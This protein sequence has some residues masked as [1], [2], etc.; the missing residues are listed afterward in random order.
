[1]CSLSTRFPPRIELLEDRPVV[2]GIRTHVKV[3]ARAALPLGA[4]GPGKL[5]LIYPVVSASKKPLVDLECI[6]LSLLDL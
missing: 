3:L 6:C 2:F 4:T 1:M 5:V